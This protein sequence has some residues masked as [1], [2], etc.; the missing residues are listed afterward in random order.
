[1]IRKIL[2]STGH[3]MGQKTFIIA[4]SCC[5]FANSQGLQAGEN[6]IGED[7]SDLEKNTSSLVPLTKEETPLEALTKD[8]IKEILKFLSPLGQERLRMTCTTLFKKATPLIE[9]LTITKPIPTSV[10]N[11][12]LLE[13]LNNI[14]EL[15]FEDFPYDVVPSNVKLFLTFLSQ[16][17]NLKTF[18]LS[19]A[20]LSDESMKALAPNLPVSLQ[21]LNL[22]GNNIG[23]PGFLELAKVLSNLKNLETLD[24]RTNIVRDGGVIAIAEAIKNLEKFK[25]IAIAHSVVGDAGA[26]AL[27]NALKDKGDVKVHLNGVVSREV[28]DQIKKARP[29]WII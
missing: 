16:M 10:A 28:R 23:D 8:L 1:M 7:P 21:T 26:L 20:N 13:N 19:H 15:C 9:K 24:L 2:N 27:F 3:L 4:L 22:S 14:Q 11:S 18:N 17:T 5:F 6:S 25:F 12:K 29:D